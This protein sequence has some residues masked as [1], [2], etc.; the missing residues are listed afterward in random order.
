MTHEEAVTA[1]KEYVANEYDGTIGANL[2]LDKLLFQ[3][4]MAHPFNHPKPEMHQPDFVLT[5]E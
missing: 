4:Q 5:G 3:V 2:Q 1:L